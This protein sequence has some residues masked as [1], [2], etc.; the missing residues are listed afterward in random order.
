M[1]NKFNR[2]WTD[3]ELEAAVGAYVEM[4]RCQKQG[5]PYNK[6]EINR[7][8]RETGAPLEGRTKASIEYRMQNI[9]DVLQEE[10]SQFVLGYAPASNVGDRIRRR[11]LQLLKKNGGAATGK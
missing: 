5:R 7:R 11:I 1:P 2:D 10:G 3:A 8:L 6:A 4:L 9:S